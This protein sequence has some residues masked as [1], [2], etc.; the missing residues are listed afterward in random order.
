MD[1]KETGL[2]YSIAVLSS[3]SIALGLSKTISSPFIKKFIPFIAVASAGSLNVGLMRW[4]E[5]KDGIELLDPDTKE[6]LGVKSP[7][8]GSLA[9]G[10]VALSRIATS[11]PCLT[12]PPLI[13]T[14]FIKLSPFKYQFVHLSLITLCLMTALPCSIALFPQYGQ[15]KVNDL[16]LNVQEKVKKITSKEFVI[17]NKGL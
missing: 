16:E 8:A 11:F 17:Y 13:L 6:K 5:M 7:K 14:K 15:L 1:L 10:Q 9:V 12:I 2:A 3:C 4:K